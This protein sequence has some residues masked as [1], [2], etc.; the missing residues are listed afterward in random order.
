MTLSSASQIE[1]HNVSQSFNHNAQ[2]ITLFQQLSLCIEQ[3]QSYAITGPSGSGKSS[4]LML[5]AGLEPPTAGQISYIEHGR[6][7]PLA[8]LRQN[9]GF[10]FQQF[11]LLPE[12]TALHN[13][14]LPLKLR[15]EKNAEVIAAASLEKVGLGHRLNH[16]PQ[17]LSGGEQQRAAIARALVFQPKF[18]FADEP[19]GNLDSKSAANVADLL[20]DCCR[21][22]GA[23]LVIVTHS[24]PLAARAQQVLAFNNG[25][26]TLLAKPQMEVQDACY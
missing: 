19:T 8:L 21:Q 13:V 9:I 4:L 23:A 22:N 25:N 5:M 12:L 20:F 14:A 3:G 11:H 15:G 1:L 7:M 26:C 10:V 17:Q 24:P 18:I 6:S 16:K 2:Q